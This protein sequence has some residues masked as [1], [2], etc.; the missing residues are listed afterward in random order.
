MSA[1]I[2]LRVLLCAALIVTGGGVAFAAPASGTPAVALTIRH[3]DGAQ[4]VDVVGTALA[5]STVSIV[6]SAKLS[7]D[8]PIVTLNHFKVTADRAGNFAVTLPY[9]P[10]F[11]PE[12]QVILQAQAPGMT[13]SA[14]EF[15][16]ANPTAYPASPLLD[17]LDTQ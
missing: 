16:V 1:W 9:A 12:T 5:Y 8:L 7:V 6:A 2:S 17:G 15:T 10:D 14:I 11:T 13:P 4:A 3:H